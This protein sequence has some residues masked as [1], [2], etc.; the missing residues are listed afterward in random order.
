MVGIAVFVGLLDGLLC[1]FIGLSTF[2]C[3][4]FHGTIL[5]F[6]LAENL[7][8]LQDLASKPDNMSELLK[9][10]KIQL[11]AIADITRHNMILVRENQTLN[12]KLKTAEFKKE[13][14]KFTWTNNISMHQSG[15]L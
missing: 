3:A 14:R 6:F 1:M 15:S 11:E 2:A 7:V 12:N 8:L 10:E 9:T 4:L 5:V 13:A